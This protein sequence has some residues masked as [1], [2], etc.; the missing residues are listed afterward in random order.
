[1]VKRSNIKIL[2]KRERNFVLIS[3]SWRVLTQAEIQCEA[4]QAEC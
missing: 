3:F 2:R 1:M 4:L